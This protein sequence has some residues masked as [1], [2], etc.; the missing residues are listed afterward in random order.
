MQQTEPKLLLIVTLGKDKVMSTQHKDTHTDP[1]CLISE[2]L[3]LIFLS[4][5]QTLTLRG[6]EKEVC[7]QHKDKLYNDREEGKK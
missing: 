6:R 7:R 2:T 3:W 4:Q 5:E 1:G